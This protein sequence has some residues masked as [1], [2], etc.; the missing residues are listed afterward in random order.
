M[1]E[2]G[3]GVVDACY[4]VLVGL[5]VEVADCVVDELWGFSL[6]GEYMRSR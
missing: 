6:V 2:V 4:G 1:L 5:D 3:E